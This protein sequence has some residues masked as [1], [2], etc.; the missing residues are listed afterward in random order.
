MKTQVIMKRELFG[1]EISQQSKTEFFSATDL[2]KAG[3]IWRINNNLQ[4]F[5]LQEWLRLKGTKE[6]IKSMELKY[7]LIKTSTKG[8]N[9]HVWIH[10][11]LFI[12]LALAISPDLKIEVYEWLF[13]NL[14]KF[15]NNSGDS[16]KKMCGALWEKTTNKRK[17]PVNIKKVADLI[18]K[19]CFVEDWQEANEKQLNLRNRIHED[20]AWLADVMNNNKAA[21]RMAIERI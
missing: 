16:Y 8:K 14:I 2:V 13:D 18:K 10:P 1:K 19:K 9:A 5:N 20:I 21:I 7:G 15:R 4:I 12:D 11:L 3:N 17:F 6:F